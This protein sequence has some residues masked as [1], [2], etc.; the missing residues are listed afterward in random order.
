MHQY[1]FT[2]LIEMDLVQVSGGYSMKTDGSGIGTKRV[3]S[4]NRPSKPPPDLYLESSMSFSLFYIP[5][6]YQSSN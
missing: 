1:S 2:Q 4:K 3:L 5:Y 6:L